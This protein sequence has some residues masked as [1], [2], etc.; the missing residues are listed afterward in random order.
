MTYFK[1]SLIQHLVRY[2]TAH[3]TPLFKEGDPEDPNNYRPISILPFISKILEK[4]ICRALLRHIENFKI[5]TNCQAGLKKKKS[6]LS[7]LIKLTDTCLQNMDNSNATICVFIDLKK[8]FDTISHERLLAKLEL[9]NIK[10]KALQLFTNY[11]KNRQQITIINNTKSGT[12]PVVV[13]VPQGSIL[14]PI[15]FTI[16]IND[17]IDVIN[18]SGICLFADDTV[19]YYAHRDINHARNA[20]QHD[21]HNLEK[22]MD[23]N[24]RTI[25][26]KKTQYM[27]ISIHL[28]KFENINLQIK[29]LPL[30]RTKAYKY[31]GV[32]IYQHLKFSHHIKTISG[33]VK[34]KI[35][36]L[37]RISHYMP[38]GTILMLYKALIIPHFDYASCI[39]GS[40]NDSD[41]R[42]LQDIQTNTL[43]RIVKRKDLTESA[44][45]NLVKMQTLEDQR[46]KQFILLI[47]N[48]YVLGHECYLVQRLRSLNH[49]H[50]TRNHE[51][52]YLPKPRT[53]YLKRT[54]T[55]RAIQLWNSFLPYVTN[56]DNKKM[57]KTSYRQHC[58]H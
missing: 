37:I 56:I 8:A 27:I 38:K 1:K 26:I 36:T 13:G 10:G 46:N 5:L 47:F 57:L 50:N 41:L 20:I 19:I 35:Q 23:S 51:T 30:T 28:R 54:V 11:L 6:T 48:I 39:W 16:Y 45:H 24:K 2:I 55:Y 53:E 58:T 4:I 32:K 21:L 34:N 29:N 15:L 43:I 12:R 49:G 40:A 22:W 31:L 7:M 25:N 18:H 44:L 52:L 3:I 42:K 9:L 17:I 33:T 14:G